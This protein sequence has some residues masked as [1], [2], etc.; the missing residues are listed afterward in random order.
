MVL[1]NEAE[2]PRV[3]S[4]VAFTNAHGQIDLICSSV[5]IDWGSVPLGI[6]SSVFRATHRHV[7]ILRPKQVALVVSASRSAARL[8][9]SATV[10]EIRKVIHNRIFFDA[11]GA[12][13]DN[14]H[15]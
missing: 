12:Y 10:A 9:V 5:Y 4:K 3:R 11:K 13:E 15:D 1:G 2:F 7:Q 14:G 6:K 8:L